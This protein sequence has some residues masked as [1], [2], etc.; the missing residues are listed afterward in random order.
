MENDTKPYNADELTALCKN[1]TFRKYE[2]VNNQGPHIFSVKDSTKKITS[3]NNNINNLTILRT[4]LRLC[5]LHE[6]D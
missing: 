6:D 4:W 2:E 3:S 5:Y 1:N